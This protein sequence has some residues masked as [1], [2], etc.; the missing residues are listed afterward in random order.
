MNNCDRYLEMIHKE[1][2]GEISEI[3]AKMLQKHIN[4]CPSCKEEYRA[5]TKVANIFEDAELVEPPKALKHMIMSQIRKLNCE[6]LEEAIA[7]TP[8]SLQ[9]ETTSDF[10]PLPES[11]G[12]EERKPIRKRSICLLVAVAI[13]NTFLFC[14]WVLPLIGFGQQ[15][16]QTTVLTQTTMQSFA[17]F[18]TVGQHTGDIIQLILKSVV[19]IM[20][21]NWI[22]VYI[23]F[24]VVLLVIMWTVARK[25]GGYFA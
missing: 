22:A 8:V 20:P 18:A 7:P 5:L 17:K 14:Y 12:T 9:V 1:I 15:G 25:R 24:T 2:D 23:A 13:L 11:G 16:V 6:E 21:W 3:E 19:E 4:N 10:C